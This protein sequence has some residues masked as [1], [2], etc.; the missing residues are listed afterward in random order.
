MMIGFLSGMSTMERLSSDFFGIEKTC[1]S[2]TKQI[3]IRFFGV[4]ISVIG[5]I[6]SV[7]I[8]LHGDGKSTPCPQC[9]WLSCV[10]FPPWNDYNHRW[11]YCDDCGLITADIITQPSPHLDLNCPDGTSVPVEIS[12][13]YERDELER[14]LPTYC[15][16]FCPSVGA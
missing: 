3:F 10:S 6:V 4:I 9:T 11:W 5:I 13:N 7:I 15:R 16:N 2:K 14:Q 12:Q 8:L 1:C